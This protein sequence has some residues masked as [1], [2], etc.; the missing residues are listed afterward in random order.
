MNRYQMSSIGRSYVIFGSRDGFDSSFN[1]TTLNGS[2]GFEISGGSVL[3]SAGDVNG[4]G[5]NDLI[6]GNP[7]ADINGNT[8]SGQSYVVFGNS[9]G[10]RFNLDLSSLNVRDGFAINGIKAGDSAGIVSSAGDVNGDGIADLIIGAPGADANGISGSGQSYVIFGRAGIGGVNTPPVITSGRTANFAENGSGTVYTVTATDAEKDQITYRLGGVDFT[11]FNIN[12]NTGAITFKNPPDFEKPLDNGANNIY[13]L[14]VIA[15]SGDLNT[16]QAISITVTNVNEAPPIVT[17]ISKLNTPIRRF[18]NSDAPGTYLFAG[19]AESASIRA[20]FKNF[21]EEGLAFQVGVEKNDTLLQP[22]FRFQ[23]SNAPG[24]YLFAGEAESA[25]IRANFKNFKNFKEEGIAFYVLEASSGI[26]GT[27][28]RF[29]NSNAPGTY[30]FAGPEE[31]AS[32]LANFKNFKLEGPAF[33]VV[34]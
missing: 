14:N 11:L 5:I 25:S 4:D 15:N 10:F 16:S 3:S 34:I 21:K 9:N 2:N 8:D 20:N 6:I 1:L 12:A 23:N 13:D 24:T 30:L 26:G 17:T 22:L 27:F 32:I 18:Q 31:S 7:N 29:Q 28:N 19:E 33:N